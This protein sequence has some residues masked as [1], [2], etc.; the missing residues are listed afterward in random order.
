MMTVKR[1]NTWVI[2]LTADKGHFRENADGNI[3][4]QPRADLRTG[5]LLRGLRLDP[6]D[7]GHAVGGYFA[8]H[9]PDAFKATKK[10]PAFVPA[11]FLRPVTPRNKAAAL[12]I[13]GKS[14]Q[15]RLAGA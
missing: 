9:D 12:D 15:G 13:T 5:R 4:P 6:H 3:I 10:A 14:V 1:N 8:A 11:S 7:D 2:I